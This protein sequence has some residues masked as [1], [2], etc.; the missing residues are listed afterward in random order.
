MSMDKAYIGPLYLLYL[1]VKFYALN[2]VVDL[3]DWTP[4][5]KFFGTHKSPATP[6]DLPNI[7]PQI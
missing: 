3:S 5:G 2:A 6:E 7:S 1:F 4:N